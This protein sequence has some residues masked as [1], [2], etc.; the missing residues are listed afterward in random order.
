[1]KKQLTFIL[2]LI[3]FVSVAVAQTNKPEGLLPVNQ[4][5]S[6]LK[7]QA[8][9]QLIDARSAEEFALNHIPEAVNVSLQTEGYETLV[10]GL[11]PTKPV[12][13]YSIANGRSVAMADDLRKKGFTDVYVLDNG[14]G[15]WTG[16]G[17]SLFTTA[18]KGLT[19]SEY[20][21]IIAS[22]K[23]VLVDIGSNYCGACKKVKPILETL[24]KEHGDALTIVELELEESPALIAA[25]KTVTSFPYLIVYKQG[26]IVLKRAGLIDLKVALD[27]Q[28][29]ASN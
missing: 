2:V 12:F 13:I 10:K 14:I 8:K 15:A 29:V 18:K 21:R 11:S 7:A 17:Y 1:M 5:A 27:A 19:L 6:Q 3:G 16:A 28:L 26:E 20:N 23:T 24:R 9:P 22:N 25:L 4:F